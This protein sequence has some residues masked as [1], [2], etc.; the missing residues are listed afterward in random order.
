M[1]RISMMVCST[2]SLSTAA[3]RLVLRLRRDLKYESKNCKIQNCKVQN[4]KIQ[5]YKIQ[6]YEIQNYKIQNFE[7]QNC[8][9]SRS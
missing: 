8:R 3:A 6:N 7:I 2:N 1:P 5:N 4:Y 9:V